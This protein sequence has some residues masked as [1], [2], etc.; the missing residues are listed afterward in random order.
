MKTRIRNL[1]QT[2]Y[3]LKA[4]AIALDL[5]ILS[6]AFV[7]CV[8]VRKHFGGAFRP[9]NY[10]SLYP[11]LLIVWFVFEKA[12]L[13][14]GC[15]VYSGAGLGPAEEFRRIFYSLSI[16]FV[17]M[18]FANYSYRPR[19][20]LYSRTILA[21]TYLLSLLL[22]PFGRLLFRKLFTRLGMWGIPAVIIGSGKTAADL[23]N[24]L[25]RHP[26]YGLRPAGYFTLSPENRM[27][28]EAS[29]LGSLQDISRIPDLHSIRYA[30]IADQQLDESGL[31]AV[32]RQCETLF[33]HVLFIPRGEMSLFTWVTAKD[34]AGMLGLEVRHNLQIPHIYRLKKII[35]TLLTLPCL[36]ISLPLMGLIAVW[37]KLDS[38]GPVFFKHRRITKNRQQI[39]IYKFRT[40]IDGAEKQLQ[41]VLETSPESKKGWE[42]YGKLKKDPRI[43]RS[44]RWLRKTS[45]DELPQLFNVLQGKL[46]LVGPRPIIQEELSYYGEE[47]RLFDRVLPGITGLWQVSGRN[48]LSYKERVQMDLYYV[49]NW[50][51]WLDLYIL[52]KTVFAVFF[53]HGAH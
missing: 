6:G 27:P 12:G 21:A 28:A 47:A 39:N 30:I 11:F 15:S 35:D 7:F 16:I 14:Q 40:M 18:G 45:L 50:S 32:L 31:T 51:V 23:Y 20:Y 24:R 44:G 34:L 48:E 17:G 9:G 19:D 13:Y 29:I 49:N 8:L 3:L 5:L 2:T 43:T 33:P 53:R 46:T 52:S 4:A 42:L 26:E 25:T 10:F 38:P 22:I 1:L 41:T 36:F 37:I